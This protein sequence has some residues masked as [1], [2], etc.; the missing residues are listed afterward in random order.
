MRL[1]IVSVP[2]H[3][4][5]A[6]TFQVVRGP[7]RYVIKEKVLAPHTAIASS[8]IP[9]GRG[10][11]KYISTGIHKDFELPALCGFQGRKPSQRLI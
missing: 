7:F 10:S 1:G 4:K 5:V 2:D 11:Q 3:T 8:A 6:V 9:Q